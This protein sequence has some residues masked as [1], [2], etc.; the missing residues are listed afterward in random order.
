MADYV[1]DNSGSWLETR[2][3]V[4][5]LGDTL[6]STQEATNIKKREKVLDTTS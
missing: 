6:C 2:K 5:A 4:V 3:A 1:I